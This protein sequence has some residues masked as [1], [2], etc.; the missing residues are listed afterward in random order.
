MANFNEKINKTE[1]AK[2]VQEENDLI[3]DADDIL[4]I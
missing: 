1:D 2:P 4:G 3:A